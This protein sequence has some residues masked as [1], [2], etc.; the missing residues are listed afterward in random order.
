TTIVEAAGDYVLPVKDNQPG[1][2]AQIQSALHEDADFSPLP[3]A[4]KGSGRARS[5][6]GGQSARTVGNSPFDEYNRVERLSGL[7]VRRTSVRVGTGTNDREQDRGRG[8][9]RDHEPDAGAS[10]RS[11]SLRIGARPLVDRES[12]TLRT[13]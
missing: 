5:P 6:H 10:G 1:L 12:I 4:A 3:A 8:G 11:P 7:A 9:L 13:G 2:K